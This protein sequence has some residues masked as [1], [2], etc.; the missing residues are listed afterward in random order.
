MKEFWPGPL[1]V[2]LPCHPR[3]PKIVSA[4]LDTIA[5]RMPRHPVA[6]AL[7]K[8]AR[9]PIAAPSAN[10]SGKPSPTTASHVLK[11]LAG[12]IDAVLDAGPCNVGVES[13]VVDLT[14]PVPTV[15]RPGGVTLEQLQAVLGEVEMDRALR[16]GEAPRAPGMK[17]VHYAPEGELILVEGDFPLVFE[18][19]K[20]IYRY[21]LSRGMRVAILAAEE[22]VFRYRQ[23]L[24][25]EILISL[26]ARSAPETAASKLYGV[27]RACDNK[28]ARV[29]LCE[30]FPRVGVGVALM[31]R[32]EK[33]AKRRISF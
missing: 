9:V 20:Q 13:T 1:T 19:I 18:K 14:T 15:L 28:Q 11:D 4:G 32:L 5:I 2:V 6:L 30:A 27:L 23:E 17:Y 33:A 10:R 31:N 29:I 25:P 21:Y 24:Q 8:T 22:H 16:T 12:R 7:I 3:V 26:G